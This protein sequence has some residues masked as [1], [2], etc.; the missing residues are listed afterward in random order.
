M[1]CKVSSLLKTKNAITKH[2]LFYPVDD[3]EAIEIDDQLE[4]DI[5]E[6]LY[7]KFKNENK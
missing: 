2:C 5:A 7:N 4:F 6:F 3:N 1:I